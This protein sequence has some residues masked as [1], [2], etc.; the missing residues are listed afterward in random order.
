MANGLRDF[1]ESQ[2]RSD[3]LLFRNN[4]IDDMLQGLELAGQFWGYIANN[5]TR[6]MRGYPDTTRNSDY[7]TYYHI[8]DNGMLSFRN[9]AMT[10]SGY[11]IT[12]DH[13]P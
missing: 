5:T 10:E 1:N 12:A 3:T 9:N 7:S 2:T 8:Y 4:Y 13:G 6:R 11:G